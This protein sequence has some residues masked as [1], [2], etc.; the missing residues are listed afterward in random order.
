MAENLEWKGQKLDEGEYIEE[1]LE[2][3]PEQIE[4]FINNE[5]IVD[6]SHIATWYRY[7]QL[8]LGGNK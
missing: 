1:L 8:F 7:K 2:V 5:E 3:T 4:E 6:I